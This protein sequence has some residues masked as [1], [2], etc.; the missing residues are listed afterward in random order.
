[1]SWLARME[2]LSLASREASV[3]TSMVAGL[4]CAPSQVHKGPFV[5][6]A[7]SIFFPFVS[8]ATAI[9]T[10]VIWHINVVLLF[11]K[12]RWRQ[13]SWTVLLASCGMLLPWALQP[14]DLSLKSGSHTPRRG[15][16]IRL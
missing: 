4:F 3:L 11:M 5:H 1:M 6:I 16:D 9:L 12:E 8:L 2:D 14:A 13:Q 7:A 10:E 15:G